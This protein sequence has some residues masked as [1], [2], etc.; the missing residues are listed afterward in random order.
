MGS[1]LLLRGSSST[2][3]T[4][5]KGEKK[6]IFFQGCLFTYTCNVCHMDHRIH[7]TKGDE[8]FS[9][10]FSLAFAVDLITY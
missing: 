8:D 10:N 1:L 9:N 7:T 3:Y 6:G 5:S 4:T 2:F